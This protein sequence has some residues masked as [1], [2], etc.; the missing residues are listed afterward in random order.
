MAGC[1]QTVT[2]HGHVKH[3]QNYMGV[4]LSKPQLSSGRLPLFCLWLKL[5][6]WTCAGLAP[7][8]FYT[9]PLVASSSFVLYAD[10]NFSSE[11]FWL[12]DVLYHHVHNNHVFCMW[13]EFC[14]PLSL[15]TLH[16]WFHVSHNLPSAVLAGVGDYSWSSCGITACLMREPWIIVILFW[17]NT[18][19]RVRIL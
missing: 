8:L 2:F 13:L 1:W 15:C 9:P 6:L 17:N 16:V 11:C 14:C 4:T 18:K 19:S 3:F 10:A 5:L 7:L 12:V